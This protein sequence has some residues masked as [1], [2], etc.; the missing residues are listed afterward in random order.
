MQ[1]FRILTATVV[2]A[3][4]AAGCGGSDVLTDDGAETIE[5]DA[6]AAATDP[7][8]TTDG[9]ESSPANADALDFVA[10]NLAGGDLRGV[11]YAGGDVV[12]WMWAPWCPTCN[13]EAPH[14]SSVSAE[15]ADQVTFI[16]VPGKDTQEAMRD[17]VEEYDL[18]H[19]VQAVDE[20]G[21]LWAMYGVGYQPATVFINQ[22]GS[23]ELHAGAISEQTLRDELDALIAA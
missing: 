7:G 10:P 3:L 15:Y 13:R 12:L 14:I 17:F 2:L 1:R 23:V 6:S 16:G 11:D 21:S 20:D 18:H 22:D 5:R 9:D 19:M 4:A 8:R